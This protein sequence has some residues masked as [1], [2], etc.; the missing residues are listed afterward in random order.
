MRAG[1]KVTTIEVSNPSR[2]AA[3]AAWRIDAALAVMGALVVLVVQA[4]SGFPTMVASQ[5]DNDSLLR[6]VEVRDLIAGQGWFDLHQYR[7]GPEGGFIM[8]WSRLVDAPIA[9]IVL[10]AGAVTGSQ[11]T[12][13][14]AAMLAWPLALYGL[15]LFLLL[16]IAR[17][18]AGEAVM[19][20]ALVIGGISLYFTG[21]FLPGGLDHHNIQLVL[22][23]AMVLALVKAG[24]GSH[25]GFLAGLLCV[26]MLAIGM[27]TA[28][29]VA[30]AGVVVAVW[31]LI[32]GAK[33]R[34][35]AAG[36]GIAFAA[37]SAVVFAATV[38]PADWATVR[39][40]S[41]SVTHLGLGALA[42]CGLAAIALTPALGGTSRM[43]AVSL[44]ALGALTA[45]A[46][47]LFFPQ[48]LADPYAALD[49]DLKRYWL[50]AITEAQPLWQVLANEPRTAIGHYV[51]PLI[52]LIVVAWQLRRNG[53]SRKEMIVAAFLAAAVLV[54]IWQIRGSR[55]SIPLAS[56]PL[57]AWVAGFRPNALAK[58]STAATL[59]LVG[60]WLASLNVVWIAIAVA[61]ALPFE[62]AEPK[63]DAA[64]ASVRRCERS[65]DFA[66]LAALP[67][68]TV[69]AISNLGAPILAN[70]PHRALA[71]PY[72][73]NID[74]NLATLRAFMGSRKEA[75]D[76][77]REH[78]VG[79]V[80]LCRGNDESD[81]LVGWAPSG[82]LAELIHNDAPAWLE[83]LPETA[84]QP[85]EIYR[86][87]ATR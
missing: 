44:V 60:A 35:L 6:L 83:V 78:R 46:A 45:A 22:T 54:S 57:A 59:K 77:I 50:N 69:L 37:L 4:W 23:L 63:E 49:P 41:F 24:P 71:G 9:A 25:A 39:C 31:F 82:F 68:A 76:I 62:A 10:V 21:I 81:A 56:L 16:R 29:F 75:A 85:L 36:F 12:G 79:L 17:R 55:F 47:V 87:R 40:D 1:D 61:L 51:T 67:P 33:A 86:V 7:M 32:D 73:R 74:G 2:F 80:A 84:G 70:T 53:L 66:T 18:L 64:T 5:G 26:L 34:G 27:E 3:S 19:L 28:P 15:A 38:S 8:H 65:A 52:A 72:H 13:E 42:G 30:V 14:T 48:C 11:A 20:P 58:Q 43:R